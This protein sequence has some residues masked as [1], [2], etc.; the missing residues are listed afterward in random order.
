MTASTGERSGEGDGSR[1][2]VWVFDLMPFG[3]SFIR[4]VQAVLHAI[5]DG[6]DDLIT[7]ESARIGIITFDESLHFYDIG[8]GTV[9]GSDG[10]V[11]LGHFF[12]VVA[13]VIVAP[14]LAELCIGTEDVLLPRHR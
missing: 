1:L 9:C 10:H 6:L 12:N 2:S 11:L 3:L 14:T 4:V 5:G 8:V 7:D 13:V